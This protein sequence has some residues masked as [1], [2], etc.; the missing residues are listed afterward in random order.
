M[1]EANVVT[2]AIE[3][4]MVFAGVGIP[5]LIAGVSVW[6]RV[7]SGQNTEIS[8]L[9]RCNHKDHAEIRKEIVAATETNTEHLMELRDKIQAIWE[10]LV[11]EKRE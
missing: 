2:E 1:T 7:E 9:Q 10:H 8:N 11:K 3:T 4:W 6:W 5:L